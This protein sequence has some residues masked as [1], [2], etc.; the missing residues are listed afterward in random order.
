[1][2]QTIFNGLSMSLADSVPGV[3][4]GTIAYILG[5]YEQFI[6]ALHALFGKNSTE[7]KKALLYLV[8]FGIGWCIGMG[9]SVLVL[10]KVFE[11]NVYFMSS[12]FLGLTV[13]AI[14]FI[15]HAERGVLKKHYG[16]L[17][18]TGIGIALVVLLTSLRSSSAVITQINFANLSLIQYG[19]LLLAGLLAISAMLLPGISGSTLLLIFGVY[20][21]VISA[22]KEVL[23]LR[24]NYL[25]GIIAIAAG[26]LIGVIFASELIRT[27]LR[28][29]RTKM[30]YL[31]LGLTIGS[32][33]AILMGPTTLTNPIPAVSFSSF[34][35]MGFIIGIMVLVVLEGIK[36]AEERKKYELINRN[37]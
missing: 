11:S 21:P 6:S 2:V 19:Y 35:P 29:Q 10:S 26:V 1:M 3:S 18:F 32:I 30:M 34:Q 4:G 17:V 36:L 5:F 24:L 27:A 28:K 37:L 14:P 22:V 12:L 23:H 9:G 33:Y 8:K 31:I 20:M 13:A 15:I 7:R 25:P 16:C